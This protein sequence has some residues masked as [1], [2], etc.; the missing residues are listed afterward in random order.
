[1]SGVTAFTGQGATYHIGTD[2]HP[3]TVCRTE[4]GGL[5]VGVRFDQVRGAIFNMASPHLEPERWFR[6]TPEGVFRLEGRRFGHLE[7]GCRS[8]FRDPDV[9]ELR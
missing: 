8:H 2:R 5:R 4:E 1:M 9:G 3:V 6:L 7:I